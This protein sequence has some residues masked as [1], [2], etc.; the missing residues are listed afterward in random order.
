MKGIRHP[1]VIQLCETFDSHE[2]LY[3]VTELATGGELFDIIAE[4]A[5][6]TEDDAKQIVGQLVL[7]MRYLHGKGI[8]HRDLKPENLLMSDTSPN[9]FLK[10]A[11]FGMS[12]VIDANCLMATSCGTPTY[13]APEILQAKGYDEA[14]DMWSVGV[15]TFILLAGYPPF[16]T[17]DPADLAELFDQILSADFEFDEDYWAHISDEAKDFVKSLLVVNPSERMSAK[18]ATLHPWVKASVERAELKASSHDFSQSP[19][20]KPRS[21]TMPP[22]RVAAA[23]KRYNSR[24][25]DMCALSKEPSFQVIPIEA[26]YTLGKAIGKGAHSE[27]RIAKLKG[28]GEEFAVKILDLGVLQQEGGRMQR[29]IAIIKN[30]RHPNIIY[31]KETF[32]DSRYL[33]LVTELAKGGELFEQIALKVSYSEADAVPMVKQMTS[34]LALLH[35]HRIIHRS[36]K[37]EN[38]LLSSSDDNAAI[39]ISD[40]AMA[41]V[42]STS[43]LMATASETTP[44]YTAPEVLEGNPFSTAVDMWSLGVVTFILLAGYPPFYTENID[45]VAELHRQITTADYDFHEDYW[46]NISKDAKDFIS[47]L[48][49]VD[50]NKRLSAEDGL[51]HPWLQQK[52]T[53]PLKKTLERMNTFNE[54][55]R[56][57]KLAASAAALKFSSRLTSSKTPNSRR[58]KPTGSIS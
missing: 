26:K 34:A 32:S 44:T 25:K 10:I 57:I 27:V 12:K 30:I 18:L 40:F 58:F 47:K 1:N 29:E 37:P 31:L 54:S 21:A 49:V 7:A 13:V 28:T 20:P 52:N 6:F 45:D 35:K 2:Y 53:K 51:K 42:M 41:R 17:D 23:L 9:A 4:R 38:I 48:L 24:Q 15:I 22:T 11:D 33:Y 14:V 3:I 36:I 55:R 43:S 39:K 16:Y 50:P 56:D 46:G 19:V 8:V 5:G